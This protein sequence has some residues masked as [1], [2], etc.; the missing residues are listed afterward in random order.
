MAS[1]KRRTTSK[2]ETR[3]VARYRTPDGK[4]RSKAHGLR[5]DAER[6]L[7]N[8]EHSKLTGAYVDPSA[9][10]KTFKRYAEEWRVSQPHRASTA[11]SVEQDLRLHVYPAIGDRPIG[12]IKPSE[13]QA[14]ITK[15]SAQLASSTLERVKGR[16]TAVFRS[17][18][19]DRLIA[20]DPS[21]EVRLPRGRTRSNAVKDVLTGEQV[22]ALAD[23]MPARYRA[24]VLTDAGTGLRPAEL[25]GLALDRIDFL[26][27]TV[28]VDQQIV[29]VRGEGVKLV[30]DLK[31][32]TSYRT[33]PLPATV[34]EVLA[35]HLQRWPVENDLGL[36]FTNERG[37]PIQQHPFATALARA[38]TIAGIPGWATPK[39]LRHFYASLLIRQG[40]S[41]KVVQTR[42]GH[43]SA[44]IT[45]DIYGHLWPDEED[46]TR[47]AVDGEFRANLD[48]A[49]GIGS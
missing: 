7:A 30:P 10:R 21:V 17:A 18:V 49:E 23:A 43:A 6:F 27:R 41:V 45:L 3:W 33:V 29:R 34:I 22:F 24:A 36:V 25:F 11:I 16:A 20:L 12:A 13:V 35:A 31:T 38:L 9:G 48:V 32:E 5:V 28:R 40:L 4:S 2:G 46:R 8:I 44:K 19:R 47:S 26:R 39:A 14:L 15:R 37:S 42:M 1:I